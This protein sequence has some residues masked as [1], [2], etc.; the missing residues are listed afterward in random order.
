VDPKD[1][2]NK[3]KVLTE[4]IKFLNTHIHDTYFEDQ[5]E[6]YFHFIG[7]ITSINSVVFKDSLWFVDNDK[8]R[9]L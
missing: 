7:S 5:N 4:S 8:T 2:S 9:I 6:R 3:L 1:N